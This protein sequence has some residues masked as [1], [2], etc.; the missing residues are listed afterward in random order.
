MI[1]L[2]KDIQVTKNFSMQEFANTKDGN[3]LQLDLDL[4]YKLQVLRDIV[5]SITITSGYR[6]PKYNQS[7]GGSSNSY[8]LEGKAADIKFDF[9]IWD[10][11]TLKRL[12]SGLGF[13]NIGL[14]LKKG[15]FAW[16][17]VDTGVCWAS[18]DKCNGS[19]YKIYNL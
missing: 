16:I 19:S 5:G 15:K 4:V 9:S 18:W 12:L 13:S 2:T 10:I 3:A 8:H 11:D 6:T 17:H 14:Y 7:V 1:K